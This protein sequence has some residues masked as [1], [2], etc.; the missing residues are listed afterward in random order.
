VTVGAE[1]AAAISVVKE[2]EFADE[3]VLVR[4]HLFAED[5]QGRVAVSRSDVAE[6]LVVGP[7]FLDDVNDM[8]EDAR[9]ADALGHGPG[10]WSGLGFAGRAHPLAAEVGRRSAVSQSCFRRA[11]GRTRPEPYMWS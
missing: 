2:D 9:L 8:L 6:D 1:D 3:L 7:V 11:P 4:R 5:A 10:G